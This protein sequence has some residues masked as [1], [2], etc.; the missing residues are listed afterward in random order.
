LNINFKSDKYRYIT[1][2]NCEDDVCWQSIIY[3]G[4]EKLLDKWKR[5]NG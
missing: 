2:D 1:C 3:N 4:D 5:R